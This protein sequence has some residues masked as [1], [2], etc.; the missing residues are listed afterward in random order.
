MASNGG[1][2]KAFAKPMRVP[3]IRQSTANL[4]APENRPVAARK[5]LRYVKG[6]GPGNPIRLG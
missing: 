3:A 1:V 5:V 6:K 2:S 4:F